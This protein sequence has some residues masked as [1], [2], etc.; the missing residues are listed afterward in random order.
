MSDVSVFL[1]RS[2]ARS[3]RGEYLLEAAARFSGRDTAGW[4]CGLAEKGKPFFSEAPDL[5]FSISHSGGM[6][7]C[8]FGDQPLGL[9][10]QVFQDSP[11]ERLSKRFFHPEEDQWLRSRDY[12]AADFFRIWTAKESWIKK[13]GE[14]LS[15][16]LDSFSVLSPL[17]DGAVLQYLPAPEGFTMCLC[18]A[19]PV[20][21]SVT[22]FF[23]VK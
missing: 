11:F 12:G 13:T 5:A 10:L 17:P 22:E 8:A 21:V 15:A 19:Q 6:W 3:R 23:S 1:C 2:E 7:A 20:Q 14:G 9:D 18:T 4:T 16:G